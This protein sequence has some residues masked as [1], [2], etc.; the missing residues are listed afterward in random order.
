[1]GLM[2]LCSHLGI[3]FFWE[4]TFCPEAA[5]TEFHNNDTTVIEVLSKN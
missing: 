2:Y 4:T 3:Y 5:T 1:M